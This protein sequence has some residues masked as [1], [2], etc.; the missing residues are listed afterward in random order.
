[1]ITP[2]MD[3][4]I[5]YIIHVLSILLLTGSIFAIAANPQ[6]HKKKKMMAL[7]G[8]LSL[9]ALVG[10]FGLI[11]KLGYSY[12]AGWIIVK[13]VCW[14]FLAGLAGMAY[15]KSKSFVISAAIAAAAIAVYMVYYKP[16]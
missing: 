5:Y 2:N 12:T 6:P 15:R 1:M 3:P 4:R 7:T 9:V 8:I 10:A 14:L 11:A 16:F 13:F